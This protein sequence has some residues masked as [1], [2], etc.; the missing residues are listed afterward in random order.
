MDQIKIKIVQLNADEFIETISE[1]IKNEIEHSMSKLKVIK[2]SDN[3]TD[4]GFLTRKETAEMLKVSPNCL[5]NWVNT[6]VLSSYKIG[7]R[8][9][10]KHE[11][12][13]EV[14]NSSKSIMT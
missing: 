6:G 3:K 2:K 1:I 11:E 12:I 5:H 13:I 7:H 10:F 9:F 8:T 4:I 14:L